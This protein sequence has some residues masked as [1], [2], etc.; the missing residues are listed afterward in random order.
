MYETCGPASPLTV[1]GSDSWFD[2]APARRR[3]ARPPCQMLQALLTRAMWEIAC[4]K[5]PSRRSVFPSPPPSRSGVDSYREGL[6]RAEAAPQAKASDR[7]HR[8]DMREG[9]AAC[10]LF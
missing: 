4:G 8:D 1:Q 2:Q 3:A 6:V 5:L 10:L 9:R 7:A